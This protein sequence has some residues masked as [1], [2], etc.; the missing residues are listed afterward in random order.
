MSEATPSG[1]LTTNAKQ[2][3]LDGQHLADARD[4]EAAQ[5]IAQALDFAGV[6]ALVMPREAVRVIFKVLAP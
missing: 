4:E 3:L 1:R 2:V 5:A 6:G